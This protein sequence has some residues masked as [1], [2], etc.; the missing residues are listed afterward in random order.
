[1]VTDRFAAT[2]SGSH[3]IDIHGTVWADLLTPLSV[4]PEVKTP[5]VG[6]RVLH[7]GEVAVVVSQG[8]HHFEAETSNG[9]RFLGES[10]RAKIVYGDRVIP[11]CTGSI[12]QPSAL[13][14]S[15]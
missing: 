1:M 5:S 2:G 12:P 8:Q 11:S 15:T 6:T 10:R 14:T 9:V 3:P 4:S 13:P 7:N